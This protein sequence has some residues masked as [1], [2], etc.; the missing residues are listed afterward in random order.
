[1]PKLSTS[2]ADRCLAIMQLL[3][4]HAGG[5]G[6]SEVAGALSLPVSATHR[7]LQVLCHQGFVRQ[8]AANSHYVLTWKLAA[9]GLQMMAGKGVGQLSQ[10]ILDA[11]ARQTGEL[12]RLAVVDGDEMVWIAKAQGATSS[13]RYDPVGG[14]T[15]PLHTTAMGKA[16]LATMPEEDAIATVARR[17]F[18]GH[19]VGPKAIDNLDDLR[20]EIRRTRQLGYGTQHEES[21]PGLAAIAMLVRDRLCGNAVLGAVSIGGPSFRIDRQ[22]LEGFVEPLKAAVEEIATI[23]PHATA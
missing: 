22:R 6:L 21:E 5:L 17:G 2:S 10:P 8:S 14:L 20:A 7:L 13:I 1:M 18:S 4:P 11:L 9:L 15:V 23:W 19:L 3:V 16:W 12:V